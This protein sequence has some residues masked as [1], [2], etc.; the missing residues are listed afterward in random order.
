MTRIAQ[1]WL[2]IGG[3]HV[4]EHARGALRTAAP[5]QN[6]EGRWIGFDDHIVFGHAGEAFHR[7]AVESEPFL[8]CGF[9]FSRCDGHGLQCSQ[10]IREP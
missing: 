9:Q 5:R 10:H 3:E 8:E 2:A 4:A 1:R 6:L 7:G